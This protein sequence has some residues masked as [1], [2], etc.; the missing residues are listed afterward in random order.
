MTLP[1]VQQNQSDKLE[2]LVARINAHHE[3]VNAA[4]RTV[5]LKIAGLA[6]FPPKRR[7]R[8]PVQTRGET[9]RYLG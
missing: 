2:A 7:A 3:R 4:A 9:G 5:M 6:A 1:V 8:K